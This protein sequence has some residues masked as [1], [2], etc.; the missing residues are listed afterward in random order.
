MK[1]DGCRE[2]GQQHKCGTADPDGLGEHGDGSELRKG[3]QA[4]TDR[5]LRCALREWDLEA[6]AKGAMLQAQTPEHT[7][8]AL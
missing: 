4:T 3:P 5:R 7:G 1:G 6:Q 2:T 8:T